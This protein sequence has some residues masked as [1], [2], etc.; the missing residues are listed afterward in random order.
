[1][2]RRIADA[3]ATM[4]AHLRAGVK[5]ADLAAAAGLSTSRFGRLFRD[6]TG[7]TPAAYLRRLR[8]TRARALLERTSLSVAEIMAHV[9]VRDPS[10]F[11]RDFRR[12][13]GV[14]PRAYRQQLRFSTRATRFL[15]LWSRPR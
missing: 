6:A 3:I 10:H 8:M 7:T 1:M 5:I 12:E 11:A 14:S 4:D 15:A 9:G 13:H 2:D